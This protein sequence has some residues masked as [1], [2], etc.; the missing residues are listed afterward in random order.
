MCTTKV[1]VEKDWGK[2]MGFEELYERCDEAGRKLRPT[3]E[4]LRGLEFTDKWD[5]TGFIAPD[6]KRVD[7]SHAGRMRM[8][9]EI[10]TWQELYALMDEGYIRINPDMGTVEMRRLPDATQTGLINDFIDYSRQKGEPIMISLMAGAKDF[11]QIYTD[12]AP[13]AL[14][15]THIKQYYAG[16]RPEVPDRFQYDDTIWENQ[17]PSDSRGRRYRKN[18]GV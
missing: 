15:M 12:E 8:H 1:S 18:T 9:G 13:V 16:K 3:E 2:V 7:L 6:G 11:A 17:P 4:I 5:H 10:A 14:M